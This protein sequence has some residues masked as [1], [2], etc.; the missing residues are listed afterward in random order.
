MELNA[1]K[2]VTWWI[3]VFLFVIGVMGAVVEGI[4]IITDWSAIFLAVGYVLL[5]LGTLI[6][7]L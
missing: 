3:S 4:P 2:R 1:P 6:K 5:A 7:G